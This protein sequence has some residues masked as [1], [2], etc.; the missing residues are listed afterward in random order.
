MLPHEI[1]Y[2]I[3]D[4]DI[5]SSD[6]DTLCHLRCVSKD[7][8][9]QITKIL[10]STFKIK[11]LF[12][13]PEKCQ[14]IK[15]ILASGKESIFH[16]I[17]SLHLEMFPCSHVDMWF[18]VLE[19]LIPRLANLQA[20]KWDHVLSNN[21]YPPLVVEDLET[22]LGLLP[23]VDEYFLTIRQHPDFIGSEFPTKRIPVPPFNLRKLS[24]QWWFSIRPPSPIMSQISTSVANSPDLE[25]LSFDVTHDFNFEYHFGDQVL[26]EEVFSA[27]SSLPTDLKLKSLETRAIEVTSDD[28]RRHLRHFRHL[29]RL[30]IRRDPNLEAPKNIGEILQVLLAERIFLKCLLVDV[31][32]HPGVFEYL[33]SYSGIEQLALKPRHTF[34]C[35][36]ELVDQF[37]FSVL[38]AHSTTLKWLRLGMD[39]TTIWSGFLQPE[40]QECLKQCKALEYLYCWL[41]LEV[42]DV[43]DQNADVLTSW[44]ETINKIPS[45]RQFKCPPIAISHRTYFLSV[46]SE[47]NPDSSIRRFVKH[48]VG[49]FRSHCRIDCEWTFRSNYYL[50]RCFFH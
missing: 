48:V 12:Y 13:L 14:D 35:T 45:L 39:W 15:D 43:E 40:H 27:T 20:V 6:T 21:D 7:F 17:K 47:H 37:F 11:S 38:P 42:E 34:D 26:F 22:R 25:S 41:L 24:V 49:D 29:E 28:F 50:K 9:E 23:N 4:L 18:D 19:T 8:Y 32:H 10:F 30:R 44:L 1:I 33:A 2:E 31:F 5:I 46:G 16:H 3:F 36:P